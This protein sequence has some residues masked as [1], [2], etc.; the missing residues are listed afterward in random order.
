MYALS[1]EEGG[2]SSVNEFGAIIS[3]EAFDRKVKLGLG[4]SSKRH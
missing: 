1:C 2:G 4:K 3:L